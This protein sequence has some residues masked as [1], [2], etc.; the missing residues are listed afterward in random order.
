MSEKKSLPKVVYLYESRFRDAMLSLRRRG[1]QHLRAY[2]TAC[3]IIESLRYGQGELNK[4]T[5]HGES[6][7]KH[8]LKYDLSS[9][10]HRL[11]TVHSDGHIYLL[12]VG[13]HDEVDR[14]LDQNRGLTVVVNE[15]TRRIT[16]TYITAPEHSAPR[17][18]PGLNFAALT[19]AN[20]P[21]LKRVSGFDVR[22]FVPSAFV[23]RSLES[24]DENSGD[25]DIR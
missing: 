6:R 13:T 24:L 5:N 21:Y 1:N 3:T 16:P 7:I 8:C 23:A 20:V 9:D 12:H 2:Q 22:E 14:W 11:V 15:E 19:E 25:N 4:L 10:A 18:P 17:E